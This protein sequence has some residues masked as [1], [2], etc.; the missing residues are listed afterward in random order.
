MELQVLCSVLPISR[1]SAV[2]ACIH[3]VGNLL[4]LEHVLKLRHPNIST[5][6]AE[7]KRTWRYGPR[8]AAETSKPLVW[9]AMD[10]LVAYAD[11]KDWVTA[12]A[13]RPDVHRAGNA[14]KIGWSFW[15][16]RSDKETISRENESNNG[17]WIPR[18]STHLEE[19]Q[20]EEEDQEKGSPD[21]D[22]GTDEVHELESDESGSDYERD[23]QPIGGRFD[24]LVISD[25]DV[26]TNEVSD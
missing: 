23:L 9:T 25:V 4:P 8:I 7:D 13:A 14:S 19:N 26:D 3:Y 11:S 5:D 2:P 15:P 16:P 18:S 24:A 17:I 1:V 6:A 12:K 22:Y 21:E 20:S 10:I